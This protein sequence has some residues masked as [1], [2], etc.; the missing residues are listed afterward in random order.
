MADEHRGG[1]SAEP[2]PPPS[3]GTSADRRRDAA[4]IAGVAALVVG[5]L[6]A[7]Q[8]RL[9]GELSAVT[10]NGIE[11]AVVSF[12]SGWILLT[13]LLIASR[14]VRNGV[15]QVIAAVRTGALR[16][17]QVMGGFLGAF[18]VCVQSV[19][20]PIVGVAIFTVA[21][22][23]GQSA[24]S[25][26]V[27]RVGLGPAGKQAITGARVV[28]AVLAVL[29]VL[30]AVSGRLTEPGVASVPAIAAAGIA[31]LAIAVQQAI[32]G[33]VGAAAGNNFSAAWVNFTFGCAILG[34][35]LGV[36]WGLTDYDPVPL[37]DGPWWIYAGGAIGVL[38]IATAAWVVQRLGVL[39]FALLSITGQLAGALLLDW[40][41]PTQG[42]AFHLTLVLGV[43]LA[44]SAVAIGA[45]PALRG[46]RSRSH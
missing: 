1:G 44:A 35:A 38:F 41:A 17:W 40:V 20:V 14:P 8:S 22:V 39:V 7:L 36:A 2:S 13:L 4:T 42:A 26:V 46:R 11:A 10:G 18:F 31:G 23:A 32:N 27:D 9:N 25:L 12:S 43:L 33:R 6:T 24:N 16:P 3:L 5:A 37:P 34:A 28:S 29:A 19:T 21:V 45:L 30:V 15:A